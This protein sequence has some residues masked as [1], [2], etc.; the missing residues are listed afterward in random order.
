[1]TLDNNIIKI[2]VRTFP[3][4]GRGIFAIHNIKEGE[5]IEVAPV[6][7]FSEEESALIMETKLADY[8]FGWGDGRQSAIA[9]GFGSIYNHS[10][11]PSAYYQKRDHRDDMVIMALKDI[12]SGEEITIHYGEN[13]WEKRGRDPIE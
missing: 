9:L 5:V 13:W 12:K 10:D 6:L 4:K 3:N 7:T 1:M 11:N 8:C 2:Q